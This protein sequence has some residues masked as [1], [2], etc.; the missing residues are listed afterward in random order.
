MWF[1]SHVHFICTTERVVCMIRTPYL[2][3]R[4]H[5][6]WAVWTLCGRS[7]MNG[8]GSSSLSEFYLSL[9]VTTFHFVVWNSCL[10][11][12]PRCYREKIKY[13]SLFTR[14][15]D[16]HVCFCTPSLHPDKGLLDR[17]R[18]REGGREREG[19]RER[20]RERERE[21]EMLVSHRRHRHYLCHS[22]L[23]KMTVS[24]AVSTLTIRSGL[25]FVGIIVAVVV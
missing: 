11:R 16:K 5:F 22:H 4:A 8:A 3:D 23:T 21:K 12:G 17:E 10:S 20:G 15:I 18:G 14:V 6:A 13:S 19:E 1:A 7:T 24:I 2:H 9:N 25:S